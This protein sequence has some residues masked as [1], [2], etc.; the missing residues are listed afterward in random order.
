MLEPTCQ[1]TVIAK[2]FPLKNSFT[3]EC[4]SSERGLRRGERRRAE[5]EEEV[6][7][8]HT[9]WSPTFFELAFMF[10]VTRLGK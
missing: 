10:V 1:I 2:S 6:S 7:A 3:R 4:Q 8:Q 5:E 9:Q